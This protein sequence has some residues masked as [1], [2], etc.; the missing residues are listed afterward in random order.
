[1]KSYLKYIL[2]KR[3]LILGSGGL[4]GH[5]VYFYLKQF[6]EFQIINSS[7]TRKISK[8][9]ILFDLRKVLFAVIIVFQYEYP[10]NCITILVVIQ[11]VYVM[12]LATKF[13]FRI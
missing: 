12:I 13:P 1:M 2:K 4:I 8:D 11:I 3:I 10:C 5:Q 7:L 6:D 9:T